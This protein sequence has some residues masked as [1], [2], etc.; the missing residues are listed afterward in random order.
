MNTALV[1][2][3]LILCACA[4]IASLWPWIGGRVFRAIESVKLANREKLAI[5][6]AGI[7]PVLLRVG[8]LPW[9]PVPIPAVHDEFSYLLVADTFAHGRLSNPPRPMWIFFE[10]FHVNMQQTYTSKYP[11]GQGVVLALGQLLGH[12]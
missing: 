10:T 2:G 6:A 12:P 3:A 9:F 8:L 4:A 11:L 7:S 5:A 1:C